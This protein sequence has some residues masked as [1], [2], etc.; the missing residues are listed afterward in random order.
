MFC[1][2]CC[3]GATG[4]YVVQ[5]LHDVT[6]FGVMDIW[7]CKNC[8]KLTQKIVCNTIK[9]NNIRHSNT[10]INLKLHLWSSMHHDTIYSLHHVQQI[11]VTIHKYTVHTLQH[12]TIAQYIQHWTSNTVNHWHD[13]SVTS[14]TFHII[15]ITPCESHIVPWYHLSV[16]PHSNYTVYS[17]VLIYD[18]NV[19]CLE[20]VVYLIYSVMVIYGCCNVHMMSSEFNAMCWHDLCCLVLSFNSSCYNPFCHWN[21]YNFVI[22]SQRF[23]GKE[24]IWSTN[25]ETNPHSFYSMHFIINFKVW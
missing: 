12:T 11:S 13:A 8:T 25:Y 5:C 23:Y 15:S 2:R 24:Y 10:Y 9:K 17:I 16:S 14:Y 6:A 3:N 7:W 1:N 18:M 4:Q 21:P 19:L 20:R 22:E